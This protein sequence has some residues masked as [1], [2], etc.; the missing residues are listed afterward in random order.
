[1]TSSLGSILIILGVHLRAKGMLCFLE[2]SKAFKTTSL[3]KLS[4]WISFKSLSN[5]A[6]PLL[7]TYPSK[8]K[9]S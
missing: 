6:C 8:A 2:A 4:L 9:V 7:H 1:M 3:D 5:K